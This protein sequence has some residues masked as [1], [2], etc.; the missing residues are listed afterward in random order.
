LKVAERH[1]EPLGEAIQL[2]EYLID[3]FGLQPS[4]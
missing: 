1:C 4:Q 3:C 2:I